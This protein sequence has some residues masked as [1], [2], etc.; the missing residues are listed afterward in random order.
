MSKAVNGALPSSDTTSTP[1]GYAKIRLTPKRLLHILKTRNIKGLILVGLMDTAVLPENYE[2]V[3]Q[4]FACVATGVRTT[5]PTLSY[6]CVDHHT[7]A[8]QSL[9]KAIE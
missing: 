2:S 1:S 3:W 7:L 5:H 9:E 6:C 4:H 8:L